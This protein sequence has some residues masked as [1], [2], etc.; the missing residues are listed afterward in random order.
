MSGVRSPFFFFF[1][2][3]GAS[4]WRV[5]YQRGPPRLFSQVYGIEN[6]NFC[7][8]VHKPSEKIVE[9]VV[10]SLQVG[11]LFMS[12]TKWIFLPVRPA[13]SSPSFCAPLNFSG[14]QS[15][16]WAAIFLARNRLV[17]WR[18]QICVIVIWINSFAGEQ[19]IYWDICREEGGRQ[20]IQ[21]LAGIPEWGREERTK[22]E[23]TITKP[24]EYISESTILQS[25]SDEY[26][27]K[28]Y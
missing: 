15:L 20:Q 14:H 16:F 12:D 6:L 2:S 7:Y 17:L 26:I 28:K 23:R 3:C 19:K 1:P 25:Q 21:D 5:C 4:Q 10:C 22:G 24:P 9:I 27:C 11:W 18:K 8:S 13:I